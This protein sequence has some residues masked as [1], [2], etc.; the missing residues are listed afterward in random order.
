MLIVGISDS[1][2]TKFQASHQVIIGLFP[3]PST[4]GY[5]WQV[6]SKYSVKLLGGESRDLN[7]G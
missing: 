1:D 3:G 4:L 2:S 5:T 6:F 7:P